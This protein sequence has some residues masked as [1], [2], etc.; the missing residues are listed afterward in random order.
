MKIEKEVEDVR[1]KIFFLSSNNKK[2]HLLELRKG[3]SRGGHYH[4][5]PTK[6]IVILGKIEYR[7]KDINTGRERIQ[8]FLA[9]EIIDTPSKEAHLLTA[10]E[11]S[12]FLE[13]FEK[14]YEDTNFP[15]YRY[16]VESKIKN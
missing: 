2:V 7:G 16:V 11:D 9:N 15:E 3:Y 4:K 5:I 6:H 10:L 14:E 8:V 12:L 1:G 13:V